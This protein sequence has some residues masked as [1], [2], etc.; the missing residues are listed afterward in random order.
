VLQELLGS[1]NFGAGIKTRSMGM[2]G[3]KVNL[4]EWGRALAPAALKGMRRG[5]KK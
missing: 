2:M 5:I 4:A 3:T 1:V